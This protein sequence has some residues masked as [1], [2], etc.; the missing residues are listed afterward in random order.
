MF[1]FKNK[2]NRIILATLFVVFFLFTSNQVLAASNPK[3]SE[4]IP[5]PRVINITNGSVVDQGSEIKGISL[6]FT[7]NFVLLDGQLLGQTINEIG[8]QG[9]QDWEISLPQDLMFGKH[10]LE[11][12]TQTLNG[13]VSKSS[14]LEFYCKPK[15]PTPTIYTPVL[16]NQTNWQQP[17]I[18]GLTLND[19]IVEIYIDEKLN[20]TIRAIN[21]ESGVTDFKYLPIQKLLP[22]FH[23]VRIKAKSLQGLESDFSKEIIFE[24]KK[25]PSKMIAPELPIEKDGFIPPV[26]APTLITP[27]NNSVS[28]NNKL[29]ITGLVHNEHYVK[30]FMD[31]KLVGQFMP[32]EHSSGVTSFVWQAD[33]LLNFGLHKIYAKCINPRGQVSNKSNVIKIIVLPPKYFISSPQGV[34]ASAQSGEAKQV[35]LDNIIVND[36]RKINQTVKKINSWT[37]FWRRMISII[38]LVV[39]IL[40]GIWVLSLKKDSKGKNN[41]IGFIKKYKKGNKDHRLVQSKKELKKTDDE[42]NPPQQDLGI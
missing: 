21:H 16:N 27:N 5:V 39:V 33:K 32:A 3:I 17:W 25:G 4:F 36:S 2:L 15:F 20:G 19:S 41:L 11:I 31:N 10:K 13:K 14:F 28:K 1:V 26:P 40:V 23:T 37:L 6:G 42:E 22:G 18:V 24:I 12:F 35:A 38:I 7:E 8:G 34:V 30:I 9:W 29:I